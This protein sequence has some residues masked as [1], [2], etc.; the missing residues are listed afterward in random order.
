M[1]KIGELYKEGEWFCVIENVRWYKAE[2][3][4]IR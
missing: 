2:G 3:K 4:G 1:T